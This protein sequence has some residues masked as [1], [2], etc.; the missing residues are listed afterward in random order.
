MTFMHHPKK[1]QKTEAGSDGAGMKKAQMSVELVITVAIM[2]SLLI[3][4]YIVNDSLR[5]AWESQQQRLQ[6]S[7]ATNQVAMAINAAAAGG[8]GTQVR[9][10][11]SVGPDVRN[12]SIYMSRAVEAYAAS[13]ISYSTPI[14]TNNTN[15]PGTIPINQEVAVVNTNGV[16]TVEAG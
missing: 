3:V 16:I 13:G 15:M 4:M 12:M 9:F 10:T 11:N 7:A 2:V 14:V 8:D 5:G 6:A 1:A